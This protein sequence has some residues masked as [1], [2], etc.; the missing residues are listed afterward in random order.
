[1]CVCVYLSSFK[2]CDVFWKQGRMSFLEISW[3]PNIFKV[4]IVPTLS[5]S[6]KG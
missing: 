6:L 4:S 1:M 5:H 2:K 3:Y